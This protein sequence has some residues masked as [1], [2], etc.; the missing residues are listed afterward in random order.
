MNEQAKNNPAMKLI[1]ALLFVRYGLGDG[2]LHNRSSDLVAAAPAACCCCS[3]SLSPRCSEQWILALTGM[4]RGCLLALVLLPRPGFYI[5]YYGLPAIQ[6]QGS[7]QC[8]AATFLPCRLGF[9]PGQDKASLLCD[10]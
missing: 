7:V 8:V 2:V 3:P 4:V 10:H 1:E 6:L 9:L 5:D